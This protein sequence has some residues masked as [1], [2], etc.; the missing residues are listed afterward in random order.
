MKNSQRCCLSTF[1]AGVSL[2]PGHL[3][4]MATTQRNT[5]NNPRKRKPLCVF[6]AALARTYRQRVLARHHGDGNVR[7]VL[8][9][10]RR[11]HLFFALH[12]KSGCQLVDRNE[13]LLLFA[14]PE[15]T[16]VVGAAAQKCSHSFPAL[17]IFVQGGSGAAQHAAGSSTVHSPDLSKSPRHIHATP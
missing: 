9:Q 10:H 4:A 14:C 7:L 12:E 2:R 11:H 1:L 16:S 15:R 3:S 8:A 5:A 6:R 13:E 17:R